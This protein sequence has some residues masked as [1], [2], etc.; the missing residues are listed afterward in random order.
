MLVYFNNTQ[1]PKRIKWQRQAQSV[2]QGLNIFDHVRTLF[3]FQPRIICYYLAVI[4]HLW[5]TKGN[6]IQSSLWA[7]GEAS[8]FDIFPF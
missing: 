5:P 8:S 3:D 2:I 7:K 4:D 1:T 6:H